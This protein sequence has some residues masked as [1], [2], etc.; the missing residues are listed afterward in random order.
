MHDSEVS[1]GTKDGLITIEVTDTD[2]KLAADMA[3]N[4]VNE[5]RK[6]TDG[7][8]ITEASRRRVFF[9]GQLLEANENLVTAEEAMK[10]MQQTSGVLQIDSQ[11]RSLI[12]SAAA[13]RGQVA[14]KEV[15]LQAMH[16]FAT[17]DNP[18][19]LVAEEQLS[20][21]KAQLAKLSGT[22]PNSNADIIVPKG[23]IPEAEMEYI[24][25]LRDEKYYET[26][27]ELIAKQFEIAKLDEAREGAI[28][29]VTDVAV[30][31]DKH[32]SPLRTASVILAT[33]L[34]FFV[35]C[36]WCVVS[37]GITEMKNKPA[38]RMRL[39][40]LRATFRKS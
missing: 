14:A 15:Q 12:E 33:L 3:N 28:V 30:P 11:A 35:A 39:D 21:L 17:D 31:P 24:R 36:V 16:S 37:A 29:Q 40:A 10:H 27:Y 13:L 20:A 9:Q 26:I 7:L 18:E 4:Y 6:L 32:S 25:K 23:N 38:E 5:F 8:A 2:P 19:V 22:A 1:L 34:G